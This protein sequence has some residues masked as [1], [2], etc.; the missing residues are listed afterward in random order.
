MSKNTSII[1]KSVIEK[2]GY[3]LY[4]PF[5]YRCV[6]CDHEGATACSPKDDCHKFIKHCDNCGSALEITAEWEFTLDVDVCSLTKADPD[7]IEVITVEK[8]VKEKNFCDKIP[9]YGLG[10]LL[11]ILGLYALHCILYYTVNIVL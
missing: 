9:E 4:M 11:G 2:Y 7:K 5:N 10:L 3:L 1:T 6:V 8:I